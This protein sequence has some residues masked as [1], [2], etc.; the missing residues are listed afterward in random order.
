[1]KIVFVS[2]FMNH[3][4]ITI[5][6]ELCRLCDGQYWFVETNMLP[7]S[8]KKNSGFVDFERNYIIRAWHSKEE[9]NKA[10]QLAFDADVVIGGDGKGNIPYIKKRLLNNKLTFDCSERILKKGLYN[11]F[12][13][14][15]I[16]NQFYYHFLF[17]NK[18]FYKLCMSGYA[19]NDMYLMHSFKNRCYKYGYFPKIDKVSIDENLRSK[20]ERQTIRI[21]WCARF[22]KWKHPELVVDLAEKL[23]QNGY[24]FE[25]NMIGKGDLWDK[26]EKMVK[27]KGL[28]E[29]VHLLG[30]FSNKKVLE[31]MRDHD[32]FLFTS[33]R[34]EG[35]GV[36]LNEA[37]GQ[38]CC[39][40]SSHLIGATPFLLEHKENGMIFSSGNIDS[41][42]N[43][44]KYLI[45]NE[46]ERIRMSRSA[47][48]TISRMWS[49]E[50]A[51]GRLY[52]FVIRVLNGGNTP[53]SNGP[54]SKAM[55]IHIA[56]YGH[57]V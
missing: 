51:A 30:A 21:I 23:K 36:V 50:I 9:K 10:I 28:T 17:Y 27:S 44:V 4:Q 46:S 41:L 57:D 45:D 33:D 35:W 18:P 24:S 52:Q 54:L 14:A 34:N 7:E 29:C 15:N 53:F 38:G 37:M 3:Y 16:I 48:T 8:F 56:N 42:F 12:S 55:P 43:C 25:I 26:I 13:P 47:Y 5:S 32:I 2:N 20:T 6:D 19:A 11:M 22:I 31:M 40:V 49:P 39:P 1:M